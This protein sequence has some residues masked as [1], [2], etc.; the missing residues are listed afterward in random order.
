[1]FFHP[2]SYSWSFPP[3]QSCIHFSFHISL[4]ATLF[5]A[6]F[7]Y[8]RIVFTEDE[9]LHAH[10]L[11]LEQTRPRGQYPGMLMQFKMPMKSHHNPARVYYGLSYWNVKP[12]QST[13]TPILGPYLIRRLQQSKVC[14]A[15][16]FRL[17]RGPSEQEER[18]TQSKEACPETESASTRVGS[19]CL[20]ISLPG[21]VMPTQAWETDEWIFSQL[22]FTI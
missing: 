14:Q 16:A 17:G 10:L 13:A 7:N 5:R 1:M 2:M 15:L 8:R 12:A 21:S 9:K 22:P 3:L 20:R 6:R 19:A 18:L 4:E 11:K